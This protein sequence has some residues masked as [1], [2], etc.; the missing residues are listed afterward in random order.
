M[1]LSSTRK[2]YLKIKGS[3]RPPA[4]L[5]V[6]IIHSFVIKHLPKI[7]NGRKLNVKDDKIVK[8]KITVI[9][10]SYSCQI[11]SEFSSLSSYQ[12]NFHFT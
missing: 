8:S 6:I 2:S 10:I 5:R 3:A 7:R 9:L 1:K 4:D 11:T 12:G